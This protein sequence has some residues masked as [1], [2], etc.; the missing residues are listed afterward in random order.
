MPSKIEKKIYRLASACTLLVGASFVI[1][2][3]V[4]NPEGG[5]ASAASAVLT[6]LVL[7]GVA[8][9][10]SLYLLSTTIQQYRSLPTSA[11]LAGLAPSAILGVG[12][13]WLI[14]FLRY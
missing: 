3:F 9:V 5:F 14:V 6:L 2:R 10:F 12:L 4:S 8:F 1:P 11:R 13:L 7:L